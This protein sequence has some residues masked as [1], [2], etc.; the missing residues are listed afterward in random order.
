MREIYDVLQIL[1]GVGL[2]DSVAVV[3]DGRFSGSN[4]GSAIG[5]VSPEA[6]EG[7]P[8]AIVKGGDVIEVDIPKRRLNVE[9]SEAEI[10]ER[11]KTWKPPQS[12]A[13]K[14][15]LKLYQKLV[16]SA[17]DGATIGCLVQATHIQRFDTLPAV[18]THF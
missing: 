14:G 15:I 12:T 13:R 6:A 7:G 9:L 3:T 17:A 1:V 4:K 11:L 16:Q 10:N 8:I 5:H 18:I 2:S